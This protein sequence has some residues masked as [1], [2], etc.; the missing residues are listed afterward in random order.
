M[1]RNGWQVRESLQIGAREG[2]AAIVV[3]RGGQNLLP[4]LYRRAAV[5]GCGGERRPEEPERPPEPAT[6]AY[7]LRRNTHHDQPR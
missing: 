7:G 4:C 3:I 1:G 6:P 5:A 2:R